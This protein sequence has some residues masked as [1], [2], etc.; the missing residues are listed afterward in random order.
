MATILRV[1]RVTANR[2]DGRFTKDCDLCG[3]WKSKEAV[4]LARSSRRKR[5]YPAV[6]HRPVARVFHSEPRPRWL[7][8]W[9][10]D[11]PTGSVVP[12]VPEAIAG[13]PSSSGGLIPA[14]PDTEAG[15]V[16][17]S[18]MEGLKGHWRRFQNGLPAIPRLAQ[19]RFRPD[20]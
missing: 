10:K 16:A 4:V 1:Q 13:L 2:I 14:A 3:G 17:A 18:E 5:P 6:R 15:A 19:S 9:R 7:E 11:C 12:G 20:E 8:R